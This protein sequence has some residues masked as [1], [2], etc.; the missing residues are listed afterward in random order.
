MVEIDQ[1]K[2]LSITI[3][4][5]QVSK[6]KV[7]ISNLMSK[8]CSIIQMNAYRKLFIKPKYFTFQPIKSNSPATTGV[9]VCKMRK[10][11]ENDHLSKNE[12][13]IASCS[14]A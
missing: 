12:V 11:A 10:I 4:Y 13:Q 9:C 6:R 7:F 8:H 5:S 2:M 1:K 3:I 14:S